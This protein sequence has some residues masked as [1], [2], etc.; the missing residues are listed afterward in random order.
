MEGNGIGL[1]FRKEIRRLKKK[2]KKNVIL[3]IFCKHRD[4]IIHAIIMFYK[5]L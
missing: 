1:M 4:V 5:S 2:K 3:L